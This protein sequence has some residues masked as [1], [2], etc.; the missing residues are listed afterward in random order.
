MALKSINEK[1]DTTFQDATITA[2]LTYLDIDYAN[3]KKCI[4]CQDLSVEEITQAAR[5]KL[6]GK[7]PLAGFRPPSEGSLR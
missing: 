5:P 3:R 7:G 1:P 6:G 4:L 2:L